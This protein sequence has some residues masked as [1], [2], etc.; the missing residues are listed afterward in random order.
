[1]GKDMICRQ[2]F[3]NWVVDEEKVASYQLKE[4]FTTLLKQRSLSFGRTGA[5]NLELLL[6]LANSILKHWN[7][8]T[9]DPEILILKAEISPPNYIF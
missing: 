6:P 9:F 7:S 5:R 4:P 3:A 1:M 8:T 2:I